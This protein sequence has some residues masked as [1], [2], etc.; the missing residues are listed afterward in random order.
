MCPPSRMALSCPSPHP[1]RH[2]H[3]GSMTGVSLCV[4]CTPTVHW[5]SRLPSHTAD[6]MRGR[7][8]RSCNTQKEPGVTSAY[9]SSQLSVMWT[10][11][12]TAYASEVEVILIQ[13][14]SAFPAAK[15]DCS[16]LAG[17]CLFR[18]VAS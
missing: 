5:A 11:L 9:V 13:T 2:V 7:T 3:V 8:K 16:S 10:E 15:K 6:Q 18:G 4:Q 17:Y 1:S 12:I 14:Q